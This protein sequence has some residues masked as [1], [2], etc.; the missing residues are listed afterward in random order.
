MRLLLALP[1][2]ALLLDGRSCGGE[3]QPPPPA[4]TETPPADDGGDDGAGFAA[5][6]QPE[7]PPRE[8]PGP[9]VSAELAAE[10]KRTFGESCR[11]ERSCGDMI[12]VDCNAAADGPYYYVR[13]DTLAVVS[14]CGGACMRGCTDCPPKAWTCPTY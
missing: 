8:P 12:G 2:L 4:K 7:E 1:M 6:P 3:S 11:Y 9:P 5:P 10:I 13:R 14:T